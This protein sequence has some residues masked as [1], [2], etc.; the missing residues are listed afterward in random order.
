MPDACYTV[1]GHCYSL[2]N[3]RP[4]YRAG[5]RAFIGKSKALAQYQRRAALELMHQHAQAPIDRLVFAGVKIYYAG[6]E[7]DALG[8]TE[9]I[10]DC[11]QAGGVVVDDRLIVPRGIVRIRV[12][13][14]EERFE[15]YLEW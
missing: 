12:P 9:T 10:F 5:G 1:A 4:I 7:P 3:H 6:P 14:A 15:V 13:R 11:M 2:K 8:P